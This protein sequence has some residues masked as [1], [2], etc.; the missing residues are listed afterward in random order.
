MDYEDAYSLDA[1]ELENEMLYV[2]CVHNQDNKIHPTQKPTELMEWLI[3][4]Y[5]NEGETVLDNV[6]GSGTTAIACI[7]TGRNYIC[8][9]KDEHYYQVA[10]DRIEK[11]LASLA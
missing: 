8:I 4:T 9:E 2:K 3:R 5:T 7:N 10:K 6:A 11:H 1:L